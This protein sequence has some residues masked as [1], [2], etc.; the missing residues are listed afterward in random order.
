M[1][2][3]AFLATTT[4]N[5]VVFD[6][7]AGIVKL[8]LKFDVANIDYVSVRAATVDKDKAYNDFVAG[9]L[10]LEGY[11]GGV[12]SEHGFKK[13]YVRDFPKN[14]SSSVDEPLTMW[15]A[16]APGIYD[17]LVVE[18]YNKAGELAAFPVKGVFEVK[19]CAIAERVCEM[20]R[21]EHDNGVDDFVGEDGTWN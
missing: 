17:N 2:N 9:Y 3:S 18:I 11:D 21:E 14:L 20:V 7:Y 10:P 6:Y 13:V 16:L 12:A 8:V 19:R 15:V 1:Y 5:E 4:T